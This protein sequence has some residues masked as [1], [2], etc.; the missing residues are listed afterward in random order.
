MPLRAAVLRV[1][2]CEL[3]A[4]WGRQAF[5]RGG[6]L[7]SEACVLILAAPLTQGGS[8]RGSSP[9]VALALCHLETRDGRARPALRGLSW[10]KA[11]IELGK[12]EEALSPQRSRSS[13]YGEN[14][15]ALLS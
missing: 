15:L 1:L 5:P 8:E 3:P 9:G 11:K 2:R 13:G 7:A 4:A 6:G 10:G 12:S 14:R